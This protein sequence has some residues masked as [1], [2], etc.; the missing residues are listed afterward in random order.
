MT[1]QRHEEEE[2]GVPSPGEE[3]VP[4]DSGSALN[5]HEHTTKD[6]SVAHSDGSK[7]QPSDDAEED[8][9]N[10]T[11]KKKKKKKMRFY[12][13]CVHDHYVFDRVVN[14]RFSLVFCAWGNIFSHIYVHVGLHINS[15]EG[16]DLFCLRIE[17]SCSSWRWGL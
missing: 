9:K 17:Q 8:R 1:S 11:K 15:C 14:E 4:L 6:T 16:G 7:E 12:K 2:E 10:A 13:R 3:T 5:E